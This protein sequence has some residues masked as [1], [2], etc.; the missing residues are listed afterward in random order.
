ML[1]ADIIVDISHENLDKTYQYKIPEHLK[2]KA[3]VGMPVTISF[4]NGNRKIGGYIVGLSE[5]PKIEEHRI[6]EIDEIADSGVAI[7]SRMITLAWWMK[8]NFGGTMNDALRTV[9]SVKKSIKPVEKK[10]ITLLV[11]R[12][13]GEKLLKE[14]ARK[15]YVAK[16]RLLKELLDNIKH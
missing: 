4:G 9:L 6:K 5:L 3:M 14:Y 16:A 11:D 7:E 15:H 1:Y 2:N 12:E 13:N 8:E 10:Q